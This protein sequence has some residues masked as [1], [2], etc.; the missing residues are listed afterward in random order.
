MQNQEN[1]DNLDLKILSILDENARISIV[2]IAKQLNISRQVAN[3]RLKKMESN[4]II[5]GHFTI[6]DSG[7]VGY[8]WY[9]ALIRLLNITKKEKDEIILFLKNHS[10]VTWLG[11]VGGRWDIAVNFACKNPSAFNDIS[12]ELSVKF[13]SFIKEIEILVYLDIYDYD[14]SYLNP[15]DHSRKTFFH[16]MSSNNNVKLDDLDYKLISCLSKNARLDNTEIGHTLNVSRNTIKNRIEY[17]IKQGVIL[18]F[19]TFPNLQKIGRESNMLFL[20]INRLNRERETELYYFLQLLPQ[21]TFVVK[22]VAQWKVGMEIETKNSREFQDILTN[23][24]SQFSDIISDYDTF[25]ILQDHVVNYF[26]S[27]ILP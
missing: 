3:N 27:G 22:H 10:N 1:Y 6:F 11:E 26:P 18:G 20:E 23:I 8:N 12:E 2:E 7:V 16:K 13:G 4:G 14:R 21:V 25:P 24:R 19:R 9:R 5:L 17:L 15:D